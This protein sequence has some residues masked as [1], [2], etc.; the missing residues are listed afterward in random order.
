MPVILATQEAE[1]G[2][3]MDDGSKPAPAKSFVKPNL[4]KYLTQ[5][6]GWQTGSSGRVPAL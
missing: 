2:R 1:I 4:E 6:M 3:I 5:K